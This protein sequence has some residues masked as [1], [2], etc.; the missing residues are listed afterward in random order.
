MRLMTIMLLSLATL[1]ACKGASPE[2][3]CED[4]YKK[5]LDFL[6]ETL[7]EAFVGRALAQLEDVA[8]ADDLAGVLTYERFLVGSLIIGFLTNDLEFLN[9]STS[10]GLAWIAT[11]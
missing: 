9:N 1:G 3:Q 5:E 7:A 4:I 11:G 2:S 8:A 10:S 6:G